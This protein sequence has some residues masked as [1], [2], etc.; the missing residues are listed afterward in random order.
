MLTEAQHLIAV[1][2][3]LIS[4][5]H[6]KGKDSYF[7]IQTVIRPYEEVAYR[8]FH[9]GYISELGEYGNGPDRTT[10]EEALA[11]LVAEVKGFISNQLDLYNRQLAEPNEWDAVDID[12]ADQRIQILTN[13][14]FDWLQLK[15][16]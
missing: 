12:L 4:M 6:H 1:Y 13:A 7:E 15:G 5:D 14:G 11:D 10:Y 8:A 9:S 3:E 2:Y 16:N